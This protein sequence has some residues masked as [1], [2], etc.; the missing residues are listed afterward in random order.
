L[1]SMIKTVEREHIHYAFVQIKLKEEKR[2]MQIAKNKTAA[3]TI[4]IFLMISMSASMILVP[5]TNAHSP[6]WTITTYAYINVAPDPCGLGQTVTVGFWLQI[7]PPT[8]SGALGDRWHN[9]KVTVTHPD[10]T[11]ETLGPFTSDDTGGTYTTYT[12]TQL[13]N[14]TFVFN[15]PGETL[16]GANGAVPSNAYIGDYFA[17]STSPTEMLTVQQNAV[18]SIPLNP[19][20][21][22]YWTRPVQ[23]VNGLWYNLTGN[24]LGLGLHSF[25]N[26]GMYNITG[27][28]NPYTTAPKTAHIMWTKPVAFGGLVGGEFGGTDTSNYYSTSQYEPKWAPIIMNG[29]MYYELYPGSSTY[30]TGFVAV[31]LRTGQTLWNE[32]TTS[33]L[34]CGQ[35]L[36]YV[37]PNQY[38][39]IAYLW[40]TGNPLGA[41]LSSTAV[42]TGL[43]YNMYDAMTGNYILSIA[44]GTSMSLTEDQS[45]DLIGYYVNSTAGTQIINGVPVTTTGPQ[46]VC[47]NSTQAILYPTG[48]TP[49]VTAANWMWR[50]T[51]GSMIDFKRGIVWTKPLATNISGVPFPLTTDLYGNFVP[52][53]LAISTVNSGVVLMTAVG[54]TYFNIGF[55][56]E[57]GYSATDGSQLWITNRTLTPFTRVSITKAGYGVYVEIQSAQGIMSGFSMN[58]GALLWGPVQLTG[59]NGDF[60]VPDPYDSI[61]GYQSILANGTLYLMGF[62]GDMWAVNILTG[63]ILWYTNT[64]TVHGLAGS[65]TPYGVWPLWVFSGGSVADG[66]WFLNEGHEYSPP[67]FRGAEQLAINTTNGQLIWSIQGFDVTNGA[68]IVDG[69]MTVL[70]AYDNQIYAYGKGPSAMTV[71]APDVGVTTATPITITGTV[72]DI[73]AGTQQQAQ[74]ANFP[75]GLPCVSDASMTPWMEYVYMQQPCPT[76][77]TG[78]PVTLS[79]LDSNGNYRQ[80]GTTTSDATGTFAFTWT[81]DIPGSYTLVANFA[82]SESYYSSSAETHFYANAPAPTASPYPIVN[83]PPTEMYFTISTVAII[84]AIII[85]G[86]LIMLTLR[87]RP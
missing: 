25:A 74:A 47:W 42:L 59:T 69:I 26:T 10:G 34:R 29:I 55:Q 6:K 20:P 64:N 66:V 11:T 30:P 52:A 48:F 80:I 49:G 5:N 41:S 85:I 71:T 46:L 35:L 37:S 3:I 67:L 75:N 79:V 40:T 87:K 43:T 83:L 70:N 45:G 31:D 14:Y 84:I 62:G 1:N 19:L 2:K 15:F 32:S 7:P 56:I 36:Q 53:T 54:A 22:S 61:G 4:A 58:T 23:S 8:A 16:A 27:D 65:D 73:S 63:A 44:N 68:A 39:S 12:P 72:T 50:P 60:P 76:N 28:Y 24:W 51:L 81:P 33:T 86:A 18:P 57:A 21:T 17:P 78:V 13:G 82:G 38:G 77:A 9:F